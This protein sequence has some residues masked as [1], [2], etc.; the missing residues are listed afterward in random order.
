MN[1]LLGN[2]RDS[3]LSHDITLIGI[4][5]VLAACGLI[6]EYLLSHYAGRVIGAVDSAIYSMIGIMIVSMGIG[7]FAAKL[8]KD[9]FTG[10]TV[11][12]LL[13]GFFG[14]TSILIVAGIISLSYSLPQQLQEIY[15]LHSSITT[16]G[17]IIQL[18]QSFVYYTPFICGFFLGVMIG[19]EIPLIARIR[20]VIYERH[21]THNTGTI[22][23]ADYIGAGVGAAIW[24][25]FC[26][27]QPIIVSAV[28]TASVNIFIGLIFLFRY[29]KYLNRPKLLFLAHVGLT[30]LLI[31]IGFFS[32]TITEGMGSSFFKDK[33]VYTKIT[34]Y[35]HLTLTERKVGKGIQPI[36]SLYINGRLQFS[37]N[38]EIIYHNYLTHPALLSSARQD[39]VLVIGGGD[40][41]AVREILKWNPN[42]VTLVDL[43]PLMLELFSG[44]DQDAPKEVNDILLKLNESAFLDPRVKTVAADAFLEVE[45]MI[46]NQQLFDTIIVD[47]PDPSH[48]DLNKLYSNYFYMRLKE[49]INGD[50]AIAIQ[51]TSPYHAKKAFISIGRTLADAGFITEQYHANVPTFGEWGWTI[52]TV[53]GSDARTRINN[54]NKLPIDNTW[55]SIEQIKTAFTFSQDFYNLAKDVRVNELGSHTLYRYHHNAWSL[56]NGAFLID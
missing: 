10:F 14:A 50:G 38:D 46:S 29:Q 33:V 15:G 17:G 55:I 47:L 56:Q 40:G 13:I 31:T 18:L 42:S 12:E 49:L 21:L 51:S 32:T 48:P 37:S 34:P 3:K 23:G 22:Y 41:M 4:M 16:D 52:G 2:K 5:S 1:S 9:P 6:Y 20:E 24:V 26:L 27:K 44:K 35:Q 28:G 36:T 54:I 45:K 39:N 25:I 30:A 43:D 7:A 11:L 8:I 19:M 53:H